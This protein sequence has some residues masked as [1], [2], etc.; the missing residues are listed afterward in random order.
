MSKLFS[1]IFLSLAALAACKPESP[2]TMPDPVALTREVSGY[3]CGMIVFDHPGPKA[4]IHKQTG[5]SPLWFPSVRDAIAYTMMPGEAIDIVAIYVTDMTGYRDWQ[6]PPQHW[7]LAKD[8]FFVIDSDQTSGMGVGE[9]VPFST[10]KAANDYVGVH[11]GQVVSYQ[12]IPQ[13]YVLGGGDNPEV[14]S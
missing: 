8:A 13:S 10:R 12:E 2:A 7:I 5:E 6:N 14:K 4:Q 11:H 9:T 1:A 3:F